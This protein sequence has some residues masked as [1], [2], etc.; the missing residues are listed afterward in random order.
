[1][2]RVTTLERVTSPPPLGPDEL[3]AWARVEEVGFVAA[4]AERGSPAVLTEL[5]ALTLVAVE[6]P[7]R[8]A[9]TWTPGAHLASRS[10]AVHGGF[11][12]HV[13]DDASGMAASSVTD[14]MRP[15]LTT[16]LAIHYLRP[17]HVG[18]A[19]RVETE[20]LHAGRS[21]IVVE[22]RVLAADR[23]V[24]ATGR[25]SFVPNRAFTRIG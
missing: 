13:L 10:G 5:T 18:D 4:F 14:R 3:A 15:C 6:A 21:R 17:V 25:G 23:R 8:M 11:V 19:L 24:V 16:E 9:F 12:A 2:T 1:M 7:G 22:T 20:P